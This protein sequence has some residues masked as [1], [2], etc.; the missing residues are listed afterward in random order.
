MVDDVPDLVES[1]DEGGEIQRIEELRPDE[2]TLLNIMLAGLKMSEEKMSEEDGIEMAVM[3]MI[4]EKVMGYAR[5]ALEEWKKRKSEGY[6]L[7]VLDHEVKRKRDQERDQL[8]ERLGKSAEVHAS[9]EEH[10]GAEEHSSV[11][12]HSSA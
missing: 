1:G 3:A 5:E 12:E 10:S 7:F 6:K 8:Y 11:E 9:A 4:S 2:D